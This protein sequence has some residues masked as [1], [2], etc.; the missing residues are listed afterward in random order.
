[1]LTNIMIK[2]RKRFTTFSAGGAGNIKQG[3]NA[4]DNSKEIKTI[5]RLF[6]RN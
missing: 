6:K 1:M 2:I 5:I 3:E 4:N